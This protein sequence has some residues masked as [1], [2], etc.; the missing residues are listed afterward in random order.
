MSISDTTSRA[1]TLPKASARHTRSLGINLSPL[2]GKLCSFDCV[3]CHYG[4]TERLTLDPSPFIADLPTVDEV[5]EA[6]GFALT[7]PLQFDVL[8]FSGNGEPTLHPDFPEIVD[9]VL[10]LKKEVLD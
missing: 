5:L 4:R 10:E 7:G 6:V 8:T 9:G 2:R 1:S 3:Y